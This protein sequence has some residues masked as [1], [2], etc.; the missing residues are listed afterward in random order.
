MQRTSARPPPNQESIAVVGTPAA[1]L[2]NNCAELAARLESDVQTVCMVCGLT[3]SMTIF[4]S[5]APARLSLDVFISKYSCSCCNCSVSTSQ[6]LPARSRNDPGGSWVHP[7]STRG[8]SS[9]WSNHHGSQDHEL[10]P[11]TTPVPEPFGAI[12]VDRS[13][14]SYFR[15]WAVDA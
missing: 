13:G 3:A 8:P 15:P 14:L 4:A 9:G 1:I 2:I 12:R 11:V 7:Q 6:N 10:P 5:L